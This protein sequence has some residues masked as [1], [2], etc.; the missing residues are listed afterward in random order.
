MFNRLREVRNQNNVNVQI[1]SDLIGI[2]EKSTYYKKERGEI[3][4]TLNEAKIISDYFKM[5]INKIFFDNL[6]V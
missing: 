5:D 4:F 2:K 1:L 3:P 6:S